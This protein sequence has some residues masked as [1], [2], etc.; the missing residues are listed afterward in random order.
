VTDVDTRQPDELDKQIKEWVE[1]NQVAS[2]VMAKFISNLMGEVGSLNIPMPVAYVHLSVL[3]FVI[4]G[5][6][7]EMV[8][9]GEALMSQVEALDMFVVR[10]SGEGVEFQQMVLQKMRDYEAQSKAV[11]EMPTKPSKLDGYQ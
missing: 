1:K 9:M 2:S 5:Y 4:R 11:G 7:M 6:L 8:D 3:S 10:L